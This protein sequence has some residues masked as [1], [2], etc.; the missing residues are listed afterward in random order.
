MMKIF[1]KLL[2]VIVLFSLFANLCLSC[3]GLYGSAQIRICAD[4]YMCANPLYL[5][6]RPAPKGTHP[7]FLVADPGFGVDVAGCC[8]DFFYND[9][10]LIARQD[11]LD[12]PTWYVI[13]ADK[14]E[15]L[16]NAEYDK[17]SGPFT[18]SQ[19]DSI[20]A[21]KNIRLSQMKHKDFR[22]MPGINIKD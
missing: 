22:W 8:T 14:K 17:I 4:Y 3:I 2:S 6:D 11:S 12:Y 19:L 10:L 20:L 18:T 15:V 9:S 16:S 5:Y 7:G 1:I 13:T 21:G